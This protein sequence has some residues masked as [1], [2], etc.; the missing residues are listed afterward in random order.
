MAQHIH[1]YPGHIAKAEKTL[2]EK[3]N[4]VD[5]VL[6][7]RDARVPLTSA[8]FNIEKLVKNKPRLILLNKT[9]VCDLTLL[10]SWQEFLMQKTGCKVLPTSTNS[11][12][13]T[14]TIVAEV[15][16]LSAPA[17]EKLRA[18]NILERPTRIMVIGMPNVGKSTIINRLVGRGKTKTGAKAGVTRQQQWVRVHDKIELLDTPGIIPTAQDD[19]IAALKLAVVSSIGENAF[20]NEFVAGELLKILNGK[21]EKIVRS[22][23]GLDTEIALTIENI[24]LA[25]N[26]IIKGAAPD[27]VR[28]SQFILTNFRSGKIG[29]FTLDELPV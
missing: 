27:I 2:K 16:E 29:K 18:K 23:Y 21:Y 10:K 14:N 7:V 15:L 11:T 4:L 26:W 28:T 25:R 13:D 8:Y 9:D 12:K 5:V 24:A 6:E 1:W 3:L 22:Y 17:M 20:D 19:Q